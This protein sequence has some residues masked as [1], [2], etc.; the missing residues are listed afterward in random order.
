MASTYLV[1]GATGFLGRHF[2]DALL[3]RGDCEVH[4]LVRNPGRP[5]VT[6]L[7][8]HW[9]SAGSV[10]VLS[11]DVGRRWAG[12]SAGDRR[13]LTGRVDHVV[14]LA[15]LYDMTAGMVAN[16]RTNVAGTRAVLDLAAGIEAGCLHHVSS[17]AVA[18][19]FAGAFSETDFDLGQHLPSPYHATKFAAEEIVRHQDR[20]PWRVYRPAIVVGHSLTGAMDKIDGPY[21]FFPTLRRLAALPGWLPLV[22]P[23]LGDTNIV[24]VDFVAA[25]MAHLVP[26][27]GLDRRTF[28]LVNP[29]PQP[30]VEVYDALAAAAGAP[31]VVARVDRRLGAPL[32]GALGRA[33]Q[34]PGATTARDLALTRLGIPPEVAGHLTF[35]TRFEAEATTAALAGSGVSV[36]EFASYAPVLWRYWEH[37]LDP[38]RTRR[39]RVS[40]SL[41][42]RTVAITGASSGIGRA[43]ALAV[44]ERGGIPL[45]V[46]RTAERLEQVRAEIAE[47]GGKAYA[48]PCDLKDPAS[49][50][51]CVAK[52]LA[53]VEGVDMLVN[54]AG[55]SIRRSVKLSYRRFHDY[56]RTMALNYFAPVRLILALLPHM[57]ARGFGHIV[58]VSSIGVQ[59]NPPRFSAYV[60]S[61]AALDAFSRVA[62]TE[63][64]GD[65]ITFTTVHMPLVRTPMISPTKLY[66]SFPTLTPEQAAEMVVRALETRPKHVGTRLGTV[67]EVSY[68]LAPRVVDVVLHAAYRVFPDSQAARRSVEA[69]PGPA[70][71]TPTA[72]ALTDESA[73]E[74]ASVAEAAASAAVTV[75]RLAMSRILPGVHW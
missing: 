31:R 45:L 74:R 27:P 7:L 49:V 17:V 8:E 22:L 52:M 42:G 73:L 38:D 64:F 68:A 47:L 9:S 28:H 21:Y 10:H 23:D 32:L 51:A 1:T 26:A 12:V 20:L 58:N 29:S 43:T 71:E 36:P 35:P 56:E 50:D 39:R 34:L 19:D 16:Q 72:A 48:Y 11:G 4:V 69:A 37:H 61:K 57:S 46:A 24:P 30:L 13:R 60:A 67:A 54:N 41:A 62:A 53:D 65:H 44:A 66:D 63:T 70:G 3:A 5:Q 33:G 15:A 6:S 40:R 25:A 14:H 2:V 55:R 18:G 59:A 75:A